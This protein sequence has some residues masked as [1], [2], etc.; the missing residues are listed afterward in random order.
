MKKLILFFISFY[1]FAQPACVLKGKITEKSTGLP[2]PGVYVAIPSLSLHTVSDEKGIYSIKS[3]PAGRHTVKFFI[4]SYHPVT[5]PGFPVNSGKDNVLD[6]EMTEAF[7]EI[8]EITVVG[9]KDTSLL[10]QRLENPGVKMFLVDETERY[11]G[12]RQ[13]PARMVQNFAGVQSNN[14]ARNDIVVRGNSPA[15]VLWRW[16]DVDIFNPNHFAIAGSAGGPQSIINNRYLANSEFFTGAFPSS[17]GNALG[18]VFD[19]RMRNGNTEKHEGS[20]QLGILG[21]E[22]FLEGPI[23]KSKGSSYLASYRYSTMKIFSSINFNLGTSA[24]PD[25]QDAGFKIHFPTEKSGVFSL[26]GI[27]GMSN[28]NIILS[29]IYQRPRELYGDQ[30]RDQYFRSRTAALTLGHWISLGSKTTLKSGLAWGSQQIS[31]DHYQIIRRANFV[32][33]DTLPHILNYNFIE[34]K[35]TAYAYVRHKFNSR[36]SCKTG[37]YVNQFNLSYFDKIKINAL[38]DTVP[39]QIEQ[40]PF[41]ERMN[42]GGV[43]YMMQLYYQQHSRWNEKF[44]T[45]AGLHLIYNTQSTEFIPEPR[46]NLLYHPTTKHLFS[47]SGGLHSQLQPL[48]VLYA[49]PDSIIV[50]NVQVLNVNKELTNQ[51]LKMSRAAH[52]VFGHEWF[53]SQKISLK[54]EI[55]YQWLW[56]IPVYPTPSGISLINRGATFTRFFP[57]KTM[58]NAGYGYNYG[59]E[60]TFDKKFSNHYYVLSNVSLFN[61][62]YLASDNKWRNTD[63]NA[64]YFFNILSGYEKPFGKT[65]QHRWNAGVRYVRGGGKLYSPANLAASNAIMDVVPVNDSINALRFPDYSRFDIRFGLRLNAKKVS[66]EIMLDVLNV[67][68]TKNILALTYAPDPANLNANPLRE[69]YQL[70]RLPLMYIRVDF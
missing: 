37:F 44:T 52:I 3:I 17:Y 18:A 51:N 43:F 27:G 15:G 68:N 67:L 22:L 60:F 35:N 33:K 65:K 53:V 29:K 57:L 48:Y 70:G 9:G 25:Y 64:R 39:T 10:A 11:T 7:T 41:K 40:K 59:V 16:E 12:S 47:L 4:T 54:T 62:K 61:S 28:I 5:I 36:Q 1:F 2:V 69:N 23:Q 56:N 32:P 45:Q 66:W 21:T 14:D 34:T 55:Y 24:V 50:Q 49:V 42:Y 19:L 63:Y 26:S 58:V 13:D 46:M 6:V 20:A 8:S 31:S 38:T 30:N